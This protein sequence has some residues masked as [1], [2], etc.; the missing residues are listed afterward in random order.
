MQ[1]FIHG[2]SVLAALMDLGIALNNEAW[3]F[4]LPGL[5]LLGLCSRFHENCL[6]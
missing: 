2:P 3:S 4:C 5:F 1:I 6:Y